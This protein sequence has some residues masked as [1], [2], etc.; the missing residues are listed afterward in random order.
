M[1]QKELHIWMGTPDLNSRDVLFTTFDETDTALQ[2]GHNRVN[3][4][5]PHFCSTEWIVRGYRVFIH[6]LDGKVVE[7]KLGYIGN[8]GREVKIST[9]LEKMMLSNCFGKATRD[10][11]KGAN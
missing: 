11:D 3:T 7:M 9:A 2:N 8:C 10:Y 4:V 5:Q 1:E 6:M